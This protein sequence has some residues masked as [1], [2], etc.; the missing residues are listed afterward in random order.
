MTMVILRNQDFKKGLIEYLEMQEE[1]D[2]ASIMRSCDFELSDTGR[3]TY[4]IWDQ[5]SID[6]EIRVPIPMFKKVEGDWSKITKACYA[7]YP[8]D[9]NHDLMNIDKKIKIVESTSFVDERGLEVVATGAQV[10]QNLITKVHKSHMDSI[11]KDYILEGCNCALHGNRLA[12]ATM[13]GC[14]AER[15]LLQLCESYLQYLKNN[16]ATA[17]EIEKFE[18]EVLNAKKA[19]ARLDGFI[20]KVRNSEGLF[21]GIDL[22]N[23]NLHFSFLDIIRQVRNE[24]GHPTGIKISEEDLNTIFGQYQLLIDRVHPVIVK[25]PLIRTETATESAHSNN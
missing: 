5:T 24:S 9:D 15:L 8:A 3:F 10:Y 18:V 7:I 13:I 19:H 23:S 21:K 20:N 11:E 12:A 22:E 4:R 16:G 2:L 14:A 25:L 6:L 17:R 1:H